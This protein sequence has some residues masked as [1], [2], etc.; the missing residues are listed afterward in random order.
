MADLTFVAVI[1]L[2][3]VAVAV[4]VLVL[5]SL[6]ELFVLLFVVAVAAACQL[7]SF[8]AL[9]V[10]EKV[11]YRPPAPYCCTPV[12]LYQHSSWCCYYPSQL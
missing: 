5:V 2:L 1:G 7:L 8:E 12:H 10:A 9:A 11:S 6:A 3:V 4:A